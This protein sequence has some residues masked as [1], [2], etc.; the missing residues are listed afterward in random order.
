VTTEGLRLPP[1]AVLVHVGPYKTGTT[2]LQS[3]LHAHRRELA[4]HG[5]TYPGTRHRQMRP[6]WALVGRSRLGN[7]AVPMQ[8]W[9]DMVAES[10]SAGGRVM[11]SSEDFSSAAPE[12]VRTLADDL[13]RD[14]VHVLYVVRRLDALLPSSWQER[15]KSVNETRSYD[16]W[17]DE[18][19][20]QPAGQAAGIFWGHHSVATQV[21]LWTSV[22]PPERM[23]LLVADE[24]D[25][26]LLLRVTEQMLDLPRGVLVPTESSNASLTWNRTE[27]LRAVNA[28]VRAGRWNERLHKRLVYAGLVN[29]L[30]GAPRG[31]DEVPIPPLPAWALDRLHELSDQRVREVSASGVRV[32]GD[33]ERLRLPGAATATSG[34]SAPS[35]ISLESAVAGLAA[36]L[37]ASERRRRSNG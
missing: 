2:A 34:E 7:D 30:Q 23:T 33:P 5:V 9:D 11:I 19:L 14:R 4:E 18:V 1:D 36:L 12:H 10:R 6:S 35:S 17:L 31:P 15:V 22:L 21:A 20:M 32:V 8:E 3:S 24:D 28:G 27:L 26:A 16:E 29:G 13:G 37:D 25:R